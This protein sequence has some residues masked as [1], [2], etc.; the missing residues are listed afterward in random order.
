MGRNAR[1][2]PELIARRTERCSQ[3]ASSATSSTV[4]YRAALTPLSRLGVDS[5]RDRV[6]G[7]GFAG[8]LLIETLY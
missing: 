4:K 3:R 5:R 6:G 2:R 7:R 1:S 8:W